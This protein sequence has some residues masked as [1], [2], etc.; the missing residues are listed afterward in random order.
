MDV[1]EVKLLNS[2]PLDDH[3]HDEELNKLIPLYKEVAEEFCNNKFE[4]PYPA[5]VK[6]FI[7][8]CIKYGETGNVA[9]RSMGSVSYTFVTDLPKTLYKP[10]IPH[11]KLRW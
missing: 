4:T 2:K 5:G 10:L 9:G 1:K 6:K 3:T 8:D 11:R 7:A